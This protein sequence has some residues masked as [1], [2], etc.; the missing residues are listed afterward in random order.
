MPTEDNEEIE[1]VEICK[2]C[3]N[4]QKIADCITLKQLLIYIGACLA[5]LL[6]VIN[7]IIDSKVNS[8]LE[9]VVQSIGDLKSDLKVWNKTAPLQYVTH[10][11]FKKAMDNKVDYDRIDKRHLKD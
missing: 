5:G 1:E 3:K 6:F 9:K 10:K 8:S 2:V 11:D 4:E 7:L